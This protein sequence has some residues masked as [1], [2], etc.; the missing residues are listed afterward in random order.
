[1]VLRPGDVIDTGTPAGVALGLPGTP[2]LRPGDIV[3]LSIDG[4]G[5]RRQTSIQA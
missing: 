4:L 2:H 3:D 5:S 1:M